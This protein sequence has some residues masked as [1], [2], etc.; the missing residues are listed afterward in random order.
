MITSLHNSRIKAARALQ[1]R[2]QREH[3]GRVL[4]EGLRLIEDALE[5]GYAPEALFYTAD[6]MADPGA[7]PWRARPAA[8]PRRSALR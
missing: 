1:R 4:V 6:V 5:A 3:E 2:R 8:P 7:P